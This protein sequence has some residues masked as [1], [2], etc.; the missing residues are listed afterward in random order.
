VKWGDACFDLD[1]DGCLDL[2]A[3]SGHVNPQVDDLPSGHRY[4][5]PK[6]LDVNQSDGT[7]CDAQTLAGPSMLA[8]RASRSCGG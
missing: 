5:E 2:I 7:F 6:P 3:L 4:R 8:P 1:N